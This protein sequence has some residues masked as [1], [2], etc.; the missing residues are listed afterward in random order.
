MIIIMRFGENNVLCPKYI[1]I[2]EFR[3]IRGETYM[4]HRTFLFIIQKKNEKVEEHDIFVN[5]IL[6]HFDFKKIPRMNNKKIA[7]K[8]PQGAPLLFLDEMGIA[9]LIDF[10]AILKLQK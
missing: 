7:K 1:D 3:G 8:W 5:Q 4:V 2:Y 6:H 9:V 10:I